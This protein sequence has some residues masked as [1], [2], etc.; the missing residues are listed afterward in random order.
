M[1]AVVPVRS[2]AGAASNCAAANGH[3][4]TITVYRCGWWD[5]EFG[6]C[7]DENGCRECETWWRDDPEFRRM[8]CELDYGKGDWPTVELTH[9]EYIRDYGRCPSTCR[10][11][12]QGKLWEHPKNESNPLSKER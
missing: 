12:E 6:E 9:G 3:I 11:A 4:R 7:G 5:D 8:M 10:V 2:D 1:G